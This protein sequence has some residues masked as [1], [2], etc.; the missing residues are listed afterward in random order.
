MYS[1]F[2]LKPAAPGV[3]TNRSKFVGWSSLPSRAPDPRS[4]L[5]RKKAVLN[6]PNHDLQVQSGPQ[7]HRRAGL[8]SPR[9]DLPAPGS[10]SQSERE[11]E[12]PPC[13]KVTTSAPLTAAVA[14]KAPIAA[15][16]PRQ[17]PGLRLPPSPPKVTTSTPPPQ[18]A[19]PIQS[20]RKANAMCAEIARISMI[21]H[22][23]A[24]FFAR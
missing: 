1:I 21:P 23:I 17:N 9:T 2:K 22:H 8:L 19:S 24:V 15:P 7:P 6:V 12:G 16:P 4:R 13:P 5:E 14:P 3:P 10:R 18:A 11:P 20:E